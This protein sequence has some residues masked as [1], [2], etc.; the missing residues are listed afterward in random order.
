MHMYFWQQGFIGNSAD[1]PFAGNSRELSSYIPSNLRSI[2]RDDSLFRTIM[3]IHRQPGAECLQSVVDTECIY[4]G[5][6]RSK[7][8]FT[9][10]ESP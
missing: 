3:R 6:N 5:S 7:P 8:A 1:R 9:G 10:D 4:Y 2:P